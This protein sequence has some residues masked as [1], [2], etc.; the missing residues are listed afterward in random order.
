MTLADASRAASDFVF[1]R[2]TPGACAFLRQFDFIPLRDT[3]RLDDVLKEEDVLIVRAVTGLGLVIYDARR[4]PHRV[5][6]GG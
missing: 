4:R 5:G 6:G 3:Y 2:T 1:L